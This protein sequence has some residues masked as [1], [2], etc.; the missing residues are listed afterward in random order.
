MKKIKIFNN[1][2][3]SV[4]DIS[5]MVVLILSAVVLFIMSMKSFNDTYDANVSYAKDTL[6]EKTIQYANEVEA[7]FNEKFAILD[8]VSTL[9]EINGMNWSNQYNYIR[10]KEED[11]GFEHL[12]IMDM[13]G[14]GYYVRDN[15][16]KNQSGDK[17]YLDVLENEKFITEPFMDY[18]NNKSITTL[19]SSIYDGTEKIGVLCGVMDLSD[20]FNLVASMQT[21]SGLVVVVNDSGEY[22]AS[23]DMTLVHQK[24]NI[25]KHYSDKDKHDISFI[26]DNLNS[27]T[28][29]TGTI[30]IDNVE[31]YAC[32][33]NIENCT[34]K[35]I[36]TIEKS[37]TM[38][39]MDNILYTQIASVIILV[40]IILVTLRFVIKLIKKE[41]MAFIDS[42]TGIANRARCSVIMD[43]METHVK[44]S[45]MVV[46]FDLN[47]FKHI[48]DEFGH[49]QGDEALKSFAKILNKTFGKYGF[50]GRMGGDEFIA[51][52]LNSS[53]EAYEKMVADMKNMLNSL[54]ADKNQKFLISPSYGNA[55]RPVNNPDDITVQ[56][57]YEEADKNMYAYKEVYKAMKNEIK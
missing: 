50:I 43:K 12:F 36:C 10:G 21:D 27:E 46:C 25:V 41:R 31:Y 17:F 33:T 23:S 2:K 53:Q 40:I 19:C 42:V 9:P 4:S 16:I 3:L 26:K 35:L 15:V 51:I 47:D 34:W 30:T 14:Y 57:L 49:Q 8:Y 11:L 45:V 24:E 20:V 54:N 56:V 28:D 48:N 22:V 5:L 44:E 52:L 37:E 13:E 39:D 32:I 6:A 7:E 38:G 1:S 55:I 29:V 18:D